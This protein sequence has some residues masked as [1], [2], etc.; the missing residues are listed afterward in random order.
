MANFASSGTRDIVPSSF[1]ISQITPAG[2]KAGDARQV[3]G[4]FGMPGANEDATLAGPQRKHVSRASQIARLRRPVD[5]HAHG[6]GTVGGGDAGRR[7]LARVDRHAH[8]RVPVGRIVVHLER[9]R[10]LVQAL[11]GQG[12]ANQATTVARHEVDRLR[13]HLRSGHR[14]V[15]LV[16][17]PLIVNDDD[18]ATGADSVHGFLDGRERTAPAGALRNAKLACLWWS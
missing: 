1:M 12:Q 8:R 2:V 15:A 3:D 6:L 7:V 18:H 14:Q 10:E 11:G 13:R 16:L 4:R 5:G 9:N 17:P